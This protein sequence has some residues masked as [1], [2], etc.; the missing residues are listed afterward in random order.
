MQTHSSL[1]KIAQHWTDSGWVTHMCIGKLAII[2]SNNGLL[3]GR[4]QAI[5]W[6]NAGILLIGPLG[7]KFS[8][9]FNEIHKFS[10]T[11][12]HLK[13]L[14]V[15]WRPFCL[16]LNML[17]DYLPWDPRDDNYAFS[18]L[19]MSVHKTVSMQIVNKGRLDSPHSDHE[20]I[21]N[22]MFRHNIASDIN[23]VKYSV[24]F[25]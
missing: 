17:N 16:C 10:F 3:P 25:L 8:E 7:A 1:I 15:K 24:V 9:K 21:N 12:M 14:S 18:F 23:I 22:S 4:C 5:I 2:G 6:T 19:P 11:K 13:M 20:Y